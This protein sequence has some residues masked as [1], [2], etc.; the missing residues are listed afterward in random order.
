MRSP[1]LILPP[2]K[3]AAFTLVEILVSS[4]VLALL[5]SI[6]L[7][8]TGTTSRLWKDTTT[9]MQA[10]SDARLALNEIG[11]TLSQAVLNPYWDYDTLPTP[12]K[13]ER[14]SELQ[15]LTARMSQ[16]GRSFTAAS[17][18]TCGVFFQAPTGVTWD[19]SS[20]GD[21]PSMLNAYGYFIEFGSD[22][23]DLPSFLPTAKFLRYR[24]R[25]KQW[26]VPSEKFKMYT[27][28]AGTNGK[29]YLG[30]AT[31]DWINFADVAPRTIAENVIALFFLPRTSALSGTTGNEMTDNFLYNSRNDGAGVLDLAQKHQL[32]PSVEVVLVAI[33]EPSAQRVQGTSSEPPP[34]VD[35]ASFTTPQTFEQDL[36]TLQTNLKDRKLRSV[37]LRSTVTI[38]A[39][40]WSK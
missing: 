12:T 37:V 28:T 10:F 31:L 1:Q 7:S 19:K 32:P 13:Y 38:R 26:Q 2:Q 40:Q 4:A 24:Y 9:K 35:D 8:I 15:F 39:A 6:V 21:M 29:S 34:L 14:Y 23:A 17:Y 3:G 25:L 33:D 16:L 11:Q 27:K 5:L 30:A 36:Q 18:P 20:Y 22:A